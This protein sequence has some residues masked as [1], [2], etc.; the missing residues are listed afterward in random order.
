MLAPTHEEE[1]THLVAQN[2]SSYRQLPLRLFQIGPKFRNEAR[3][4]GGLL[5]CREFLMKD[6]YTFDATE[7]DAIST[8]N[9]VCEAYSRI[10]ERLELRVFKA[11]ASSGAIGGNHSHE[12]HIACQ[13]GQD[14]VLHCNNCRFV[15]NSEVFADGSKCPQC[16]SSNNFSS[17]RALEVGHTFLLGEKYSQIL[18]AKFNDQTGQQ[19]RMQMGCYGIGVSRLMA[20]IVEASHDEQGIIWPRAVSP[21]QAYVIP[22]TSSSVGSFSLPSEFKNCL[23]DDRENISFSRKF[24][25]AQLS[26]LSSIII[27]GS[28]RSADGIEVYSRRQLSDNKGDGTA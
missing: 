23:L 28:K 8:Y 15:G 16:S 25:D 11:K 14:T 6:L 5:R 7:Q 24:K 26:G 20:A 13:S 22:L 19:K 1:I 2:V 4:K 17:M 27:L 10:F 3:P 21:F 9:Q 12:F 18:D